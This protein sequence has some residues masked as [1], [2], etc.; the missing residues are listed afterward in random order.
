MELRVSNGIQQPNSNS[1][2]AQTQRLI[3][4][5]Q[6]QHSV[7]QLKKDP[8]T[9]SSTSLAVKSSKPKTPKTTN[10]NLIQVHTEQRHSRRSKTMS[11]QLEIT[12]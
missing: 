6:L 3:G 10:I 5:G 1:T 11:K 4:D 2:F 9:I 7:T 8:P 12:K